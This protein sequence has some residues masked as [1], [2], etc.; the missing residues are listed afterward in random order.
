VIMSHGRMLADQ[1]GDELRKSID[2][3]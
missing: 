2:V 3:F 1:P